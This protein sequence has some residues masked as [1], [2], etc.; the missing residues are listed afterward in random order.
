LSA[1][2]LSVSPEAAAK[3]ALI[4]VDCTVLIGGGG[5]AVMVRVGIAGAEP[6]MMTLISRVII[7][8]VLVVVVV[9]EQIV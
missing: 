3:V 6:P 8:G 1:V 5:V 7:G 2:A 4:T 9:F